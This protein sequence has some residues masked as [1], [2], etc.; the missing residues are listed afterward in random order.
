L[1]QSQNHN[2][3]LCLNNI[4]ATR[5]MLIYI[6][7]Y[8]SICN[9]WDCVSTTRYNSSISPATFIPLSSWL[10]IFLKLAWSNTCFFLH[11]LSDNK[12]L[13]KNQHQQWITT[14]AVGGTCSPI[15]LQNNPESITT[16]SFLSTIHVEGFIRPVCK[17]SST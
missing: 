6:K 3:G 1:Y 5:L 17:C 8:E 15:L 7:V 10:T 4:Y 11:H 16:V 2:Q 9:A 12:V 14:V 13:S